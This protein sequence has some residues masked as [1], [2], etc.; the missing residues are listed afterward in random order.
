M[1]KIVLGSML[2][3]TGKRNIMIYMKVFKVTTH[4]TCSKNDATCTSLKTTK[5]GLI[6]KQVLSPPSPRY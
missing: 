2:K 1:K 3:V 5:H 4:H 6:Q